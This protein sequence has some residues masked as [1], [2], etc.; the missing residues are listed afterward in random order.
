MLINGT[1]S[2]RSRILQLQRQ[3]NEDIG[4]EIMT[5]EAQF[6]QREV[7]FRVSTLSCDWIFPQVA[8]G[9]LN[10]TG[11]ATTPSP[12]I[13]NKLKQAHRVTRTPSGYANGYTNA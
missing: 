7:G 3:V 1:A 6:V 8:Y 5:N 9:Q 12:H 4:R 10:K 11:A 2:E 13:S